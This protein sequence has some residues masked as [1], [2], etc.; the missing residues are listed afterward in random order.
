[1][2]SSILTTSTDDNHICLHDKLGFVD[3]S[4]VTTLGVFIC[5]LQAPAHGKTAL[6]FLHPLE[7]YTF[8]VPLLR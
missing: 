3:A 5:A 7:I 6:V 1:M 4:E 8:C 2:E